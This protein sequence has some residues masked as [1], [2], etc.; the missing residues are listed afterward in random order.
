M[1]VLIVVDYQKD[2]VDGA[3]G[4]KGADSIEDN[5][6]KLIKEFRKNN[7]TVIFTK[8]T[9]EECYLDTVEGHHLPVK[10]CIKGSE[11]HGLRDKI[12]REVGDSLV[13]EK[14]TF[15]SLELG[16]N[17]WIVTGGK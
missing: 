14:Y 13:I 10:H 4:F 11:G 15:P 17:L 12:Q 1:K 16:N 5:I 9:H 8:D 3:L 6:V 2:F 7:D